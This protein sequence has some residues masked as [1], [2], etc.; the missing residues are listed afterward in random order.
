MAVTPAAATTGHLRVALFGTLRLALDDTALRFAARPMVAPL[1]AYVALHADAVTPRDDLAFRL[2][3]DDDEDVARTNLRRHLL[4]L[5]E[6]LPAT[7]EP[8]VKADADGVRWNAAA[9]ASIDVV[10]FERWIDH[11]DTRAAAVDLYADDLLAALDYDWLV[12]PRERLR[13]QYVSALWELAK[14]ARLRRDADGAVL[15]LQRLLAADPWREEALR[16]FMLVRSDEGDRAAALRLCDDFARRLQDEMQVEPM[17]ETLALR[18]A[19][20][21]GAPPPALPTPHNLP[22]STSSFIGRVT[23][24]AD[25]ERRLAAARLVTIVGAGGVGKSRAAMHVAAAALDAFDD[26]VWYVDFASIADGALVPAAVARSLGVRFS[27]G[28]GLEILERYLARRTMLLVLDNCEH[29]LDAVAALVA[30]LLRVAPRVTVLATSR[31]RLNVGGEDA[32]LLPSLSV[33]PAETALDPSGLEH[34]D[35]VALFCARARAAGDFTLEAGNA[36]A[37]ADICR[38]LDGIPLAIELAAARVKM[39]AP[40]ELAQMLDE[41]FRVLVGGERGGL[42]RHRTMRACIDWSYAL[43][44]PAEQLLFNRLSVFAGGFT[45]ALAEGVCSGDGIESADVLDLLSSLV[46]KSLVVAERGVTTTRYNVLDSSREYAAEKLLERGKVETL[47][48][49]HAEAYFDLAE[50]LARMRSLTLD[51]AWLRE[52]QQERANWNAALTWALIEKHDTELGLRFILTIPMWVNAITW[53]RRWVRLGL[54]YIDENTPPVLAARIRARFANT[55]IESGEFAEGLAG[56]EPALRVYRETGDRD[57]IASTLQTAGIANVFLG[58]IEEGEVLIQ[59]SIAIH[60]STGNR[61]SLAFGLIALSQARSSLGDIAGAR[62]IALRAVRTLEELEGELTVTNALNLVGFRFAVSGCDFNLGD[63]AAALRY[64]EQTIPLL[65]AFPTPSSS[66]HLNHIA[67]YLNALGR[68]GEA[69]A[70]LHESLSMSRDIDAGLVTLYSLL[71]LAAGAVL[72]EATG[73]RAREHA[74]QLLGFVDARRAMRGL[75]W[76]RSD[77]ALFERLTVALRETLGEQGLER[78]TREGAALG[79]DEALDIASTL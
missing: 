13:W 51:Q 52:V 57:A 2:W 73:D 67:A 15:H 38:R 48:R 4:Y 78:L 30:A 58:R 31:E 22:A 55:M 9:S 56:I 42:E 61:E 65:R 6:A 18:D 32:Y 60:E 66:A 72:G 17:P 70:Y 21:S 29:V 76:W 53:P 36:R 74:A 19:I 24:L 79:P 43:L 26:G 77:R 28:A 44:L 37:V 12:A 54:E 63:P 40:P 16:E 25:V 5:R 39:L 10:D 75:L 7:P 3:P 45:L 64:V 69:R 62:E 27:E 68:Y 14:D 47:Q 71:H 50:D 20:A 1:L 35:A 11:R 59:E 49:R 33:P 41:R 23:D 46:D 34:F 8:W